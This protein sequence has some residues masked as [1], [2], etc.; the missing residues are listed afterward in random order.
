MR[1]RVSGAL[2]VAGLIGI[3]VVLG[4]GMMLIAGLGRS[5][6]PRVAVD[7][8][9]GVIRVTSCAGEGIAS[10]EVAEW[11]HSSAT[12]RRLWI[13]ELRDEA[14]APATAS[15]DGEDPAFTSTPAGP[16]SDD[17]A[18][19]TEVR[20]AKGRLLE[21]QA[22]EVPGADTPPGLVLVGKSLVDR[23]EFLESEGCDRD[24]E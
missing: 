13:A 23:E 17:E 2:V 18:F 21:L 6:R 4:L 11:S 12:Y 24:V 22:I 10:I 9:D 1:D 7:R 3:L 15:L 20:G 19:I 5:A 16:A 14:Q 8:Q